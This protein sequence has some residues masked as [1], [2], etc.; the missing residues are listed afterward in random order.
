MRG[1]TEGTI[2]S[3]LREHD[4]EMRAY[5]YNDWFEVF[6]LKP[7][8]RFNTM[9]P[10]LAD[11]YDRFMKEDFRTALKKYKISYVVVDGD[12]IPKAANALPDLHEVYRSETKTIYTFK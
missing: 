11:K 10:V 2:T 6:S 4:Y 3:Y 12:L 9:I 1:I 7:T 8:E 5:F